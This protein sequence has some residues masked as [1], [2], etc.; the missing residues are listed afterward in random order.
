MSA[1]TTV[2]RMPDRQRPE[3]EDV[4]RE[5][6]EGR[7]EDDAEQQLLVDPG[8]QR[9]HELGGQVECARHPGGQRAAMRSSAEVRR[10]VTEPN[11]RA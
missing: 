2:A 8:A 4:P 3:L 6:R 10:L 11:A 5:R 7:H 1:P 9:D